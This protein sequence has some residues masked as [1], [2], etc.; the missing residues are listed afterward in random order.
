MGKKDAPPSKDEI[1]KHKVAHEVDAFED[2]SGYHERGNAKAP[3]KPDPNEKTREK[4]Q[5]EMKNSPKV[6]VLTKEEAKKRLKPWWATMPCSRKKRNNRP[7]RLGN[8]KLCARNQSYYQ[9]YVY[10]CSLVWFLAERFFSL[11]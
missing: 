2:P 5:K 9:I 11:V 4:R 6:K 7:Y 10:C 3:N 8:K 1:V